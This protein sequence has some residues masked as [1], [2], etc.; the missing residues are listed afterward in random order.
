MTITINNDSSTKKKQV[1][2]HKSKPSKKHSNQRTL[3]KSKSVKQNIADIKK[4]HQNKLKKI[5]LIHDSKTNK[6]MDEIDRLIKDNQINQ[7][8]IERLVYRKYEPMY[9][10]FDGISHYS[11]GSYD[12]SYLR[13]PIVESPYITKWVC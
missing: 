7:D 9:T 5:K 12:D 3:Y 1:N 2:L 6:L 4:N 8:K 10:I 11:Q 13:Q